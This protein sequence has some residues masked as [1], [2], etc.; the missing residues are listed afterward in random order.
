MLSENK[1]K[2]ESRLYKLK[3][4]RNKVNKKI[5]EIEDI[6]LYKQKIK[7]RIKIKR[8]ENIQKELQ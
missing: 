4:E 6:L 3:R 8:K 1:E 5:K 2:L 7:N